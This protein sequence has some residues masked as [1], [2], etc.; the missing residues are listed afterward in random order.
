[1]LHKKHCKVR[2][3][4][5]LKFKVCRRKFE[6]D[7][8]VPHPNRGILKSIKRHIRFGREVGTG[9]RDL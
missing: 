2:C 5:Y 1:M 6:S 9:A 7:L 3:N 8:S 4:R